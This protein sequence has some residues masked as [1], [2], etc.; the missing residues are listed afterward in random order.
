MRSLLTLAAVALLV[1][2]APA[3]NAPD[4]AAVVRKAVAAHGGEAA[5]KAFGTSSSS[6]KGTMTVYGA[7]LTITTEVLFAGPDKFRLGMKTEVN[8]QKFDMVQVMNGDKFAQTVNG[9]P[10]KIG[11]PEK[12][13]LKQAVVMMDL[14]TLTPLLTDKYTLKALPG[15]KVGGAD[16]S[17]VVATPAGKGTDARPVTLSFDAKSGYLV[18]YAREA[19][20]PAQAQGAP[21]KKV[22]EVT[23]LGDFK[24]F[25]GA[26]IAT[27]AVAT[28]D[29]KPFMT[30]TVTAA[31]AL[32]TIDA[33]EFTVPAP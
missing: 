17:V 13:E 22:Q 20:A 21:A 1:A 10:A 32:P 11:D 12:A 24:K 2:A 29:G 6:G 26:M 30:V 28:H 5:L 9:K 23:T 15:E 8:G 33:K 31:K 7:E 14:T 18:R 25:D 27:S 4:A 16:V 3:Q 19:L